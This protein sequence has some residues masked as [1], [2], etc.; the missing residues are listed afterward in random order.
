MQSHDDLVKG[1]VNISWQPITMTSQK[2]MK[3]GYSHSCHPLHKHTDS[4][5]PAPG[6]FMNSEHW[7]FVLLLNESL[8]VFSLWIV[9]DGFIGNLYLLLD[10]I[11]SLGIWGFIISS[12]RVLLWYMLSNLIFKLIILWSRYWLR[13]GCDVVW[14]MYCLSSVLA[15]SLYY[16]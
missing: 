7:G 6:S 10:A 9:S 11:C 4:N 5:G 2:A 15:W 8:L 14:F 12:W 1:F 3:R 16:I 13:L